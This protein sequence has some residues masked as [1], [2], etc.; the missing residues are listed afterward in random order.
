MAHVPLAGVITAIAEGLQILRKEAGVAG[1][2]AGRHDVA[3]GLLRVLAGEQ[4]TAGG[5]AT[6]CGV[7]LREAESAGGKAVEVGSVDVAAVAAGV[8]EAHVIGE[9]EEEIGAAVSSGEGSGRAEQER[10]ARAVRKVHQCNLRTDSA[11]TGLFNAAGRAGL[12]NI[13]AP[14]P[15][16]RRL[17]RDAGGCRSRADAR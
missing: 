3:G 8:G 17:A 6:G 7:G 16:N 14:A 12:S 11:G 10:T 15:D 4:A 1:N 9:D 5:S 2:L 13:R